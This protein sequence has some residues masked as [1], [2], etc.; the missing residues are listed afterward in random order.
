MLTY[1]VQSTILQRLP[2][3]AVEEARYD[4]PLS[5][6]L[7]RH[8]CTPET[9]VKVQQG[10]QD[11]MQDPSAPKIYWI[12]GMAGV[13]KTTIAYNL[14]KFLEDTNQLGASF[15]CTRTTANCC[16]VGKIVPTIAY[17]LSKHSATFQLMISKALKRKSNICLDNCSIDTQFQTLLLWPLVEG[18]DTIP[19]RPVVVIDA[20]DDSG[21]A[22]G[23][24]Q[25]LD[26]LLQY[27][28]QLP[29]RFL[30]TSRPVPMVHDKLSSPANA[31]ML[32]TLHL[33]TIE[34]S[35]VE[36][37]ITKYLAKALG[38]MPPVHPKAK[39]NN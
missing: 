31:H 5:V 9:R 7:G 27:A 37:D 15:F 32:R 17:Q 20:L 34:R 14:C 26:I 36:G 2:F 3:L 4:S 39:S 28:T 23:V 13:G 6:Q 38:F 12:N 21:P 10:L 30:F 16:D 8:E 1:K 24:G 22:K 29:L 25:L 18:N 11:W 19:Y 35:I 33:H